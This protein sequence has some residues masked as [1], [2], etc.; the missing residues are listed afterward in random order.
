MFRVEDSL[1]LLVEIS[2]VGRATTLGYAEELVLH[3]FRS[4]D[5]NLCGK[6][7]LRIHLIVHGEGSILR[8]AQV[9]F[10]I[11]LVNTQ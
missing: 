5:V 11:S 9:L 6:V 1:C 7:A 8:I 10:G 4:F 2:L 3:T